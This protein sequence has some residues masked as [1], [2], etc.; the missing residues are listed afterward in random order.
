MAL[1]GA[2][3]LARHR[4]GREDAERVVPVH[5]PGPP[6]RLPLPGPE[7][8]GPRA[9]H[10]LVR[11]PRG[12]SD[13]RQLAA[14][15]EARLACSLLPRRCGVHAHGHDPA[16]SHAGGARQSRRPRVGRQADARPF[17]GLPP[18]HHVGR[19]A[20]GDAD[21]PRRGCR[22]CT[23]DGRHRQGPS[24]L[25]RRGRRR[26]GRCARSLQLCRHLQAARD[27]R[28][29]EQRLCDLDPFSK[30]VRDRLRRAARGG[31]RISGR[32][33]R[34]PRPRHLLRGLQGGSRAGTRRRGTNS[35]RVPRR[36]PRRPL[37]GGRPA[38]L[39]HA[40]RDRAAR[41]KRLPGA[42]QEASARRRRDDRQAG[43]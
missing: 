36:P 31:L 27:L 35:D 5:P 9:I 7:P 15:T 19:L 24:H 43:G 39:P 37:V 13:R 25:L 22:V 2:D 3:R 23:E 16:R 12:G 29:R 11:R 10:H 1:P 41:R 30:G 14:A 20:G 28:L 33:R 17:L 42:V 8:S 32:H 4:P 34:R 38:P 18:Q 21:G 40:G 6:D 26:R